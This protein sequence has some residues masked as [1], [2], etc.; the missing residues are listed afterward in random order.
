MK[1]LLLTTV[2]LCFFTVATKAQWRIISVKPGAKVFANGKPVKKGSMISPKSKIKFTKKTDYVRVYAK[3]KAPFT[4]KPGGGKPGKGSELVA[5]ATSMMVPRKRSLAS[6][7]KPELIDVPIDLTG[8]LMWLTGTPP[9][10]VDPLKDK[11]NKLLFIGDEAKIYIDRSIK[12]YN[13]EGDFYLVYQANGKRAAKK[14]SKTRSE[15]STDP[16]IV[17]FKKDVYSGISDFEDIKNSTLFFRKNRA[18][19]TKV[20]K[21]R[22]MF[23]NEPSDE[24]KTQIKELIPILKEAYGDAFVQK[25][26]KEKNY[27][28]AQ[29][30][31]V[32]TE[33]I[34]YG[35]A[36]LF[37][38]QYGG[39]PDRNNLKMWLIKNFKGLEVPGSKK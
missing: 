11:P 2:L 10:S 37:E 39:V 14:L 7:G 17:E 31:E 34:F 3:G 24:F 15:K 32:A 23:I 1:N 9:N 4:L 38:D 22:P 6:R 33:Q 13:D 20:V 25:T 35:I 28:K 29:A 30:K 27:T 26:M 36:D 18:K 12:N 21:F 16:V 19:P 5:V 8:M